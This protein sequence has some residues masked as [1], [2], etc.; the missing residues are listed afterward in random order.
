MF[1]AT[2]NKQRAV[3]IFLDNF[4]HY[5]VSFVLHHKSDITEWF[6]YYE[7]HACAK[8]NSRIVTL[9]CDNALEITAGRMKEYCIKC[10]I[11]Q[12]PAEPCKHEHNS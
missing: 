3:A 8:F 2:L 12:H 1:V 10:S 6:K 4:T 9:C 7:Q 11:Q 5:V